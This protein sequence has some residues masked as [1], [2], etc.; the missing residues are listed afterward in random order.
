MGSWMTQLVMGSS[1]YPLCTTHRY[2]R[3]YMNVRVTR[4]YMRLGAPLLQNQR[5]LSLFPERDRGTYSVRN[6]VHTS[7]SCSCRLHNSNGT[8]IIQ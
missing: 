2:A 3:Q 6:A 7:L 1:Y 5:H 8:I 4:Q